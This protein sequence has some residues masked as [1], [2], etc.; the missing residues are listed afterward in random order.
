MQTTNSRILVMILVAIVV[1]LGVLVYLAEDTVAQPPIGLNS[2]TT[3]SV[4]I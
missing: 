3:F 1:V 2:P 4:D